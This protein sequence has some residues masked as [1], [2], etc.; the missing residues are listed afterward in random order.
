MKQKPYQIVTDTSC[1]FTKQDYQIHNLIYV[2]FSITFDSQQYFKEITNLSTDEFYEKLG[3]SNQFPKTT[4]PSVEDYIEAFQPILNAK[5]DI[6]CICIS[7]KLSQ[8]YEHAIT[9]QNILSKEFPLQYIYIVDSLSCGSIQHFLIE[10][11]LEMKAKNY[12]F[13]QLHE[14]LDIIK[15]TSKIYATL[16]NLDYMQNS[17]RI[18]KPI[19]FF[20]DLMNL[21]PILKIEHGEI[22]LASKTVG[23]K[24]A[25]QKLY[26]ILSYDIGLAKHDYRLTIFYA[27]TDFY[28]IC[29]V[30]QHKLEKEGFLFTKTPLL[31]TGATITTHTGPTC[32][33]IGYSKIYQNM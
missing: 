29:L 18:N 4:P 22:S 8:S 11:S 9:A 1:D 15:Q 5:E 32:I 6:I 23:Q 25:F 13:R 12:S 27:S 21:K 3:E 7:S 24:N 20:S 30:I 31:Q 14:T 16:D 2:P 10:Q 26:E 19:A 33:G 28:K 17:G